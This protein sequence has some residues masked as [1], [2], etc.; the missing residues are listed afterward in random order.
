MKL[1][2]FIILISILRESPNNGKV[3]SHNQEEMT[4]DSDYSIEDIFANSK[5][6]ENIR[7]NLRLISVEYFSFDN[8]LHRGQILIHKDLLND[9]IEI[10]EII[11][12]EKFPVG[13]VIPINKYDW[14][15][16]HSM[17]DNNTSAFNYRYVKGTGTLSS[18]ASGRAIDI[19]PKL[20]PYVKSGKTYPANFRYDTSLKGTITAES[21]LVKE[22]KKRGWNWGGFWSSNKDYQH[23]EKMK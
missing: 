7:K 8:K 23:F 10:F 2:Y 11:K 12:R 13:K 19:N 20:N 5:I 16:E 9:I 21:F 15:D 6:P 22:F 18:H 3:D 17:N 14:S 1:L 4:L